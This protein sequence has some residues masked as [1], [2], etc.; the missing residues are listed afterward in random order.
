M[1]APCRGA[2]AARAAG[3]ALMELR[4]PGWLSRRARAGRL[5]RLNPSAFQNSTLA[6][7]AW[8]RAR[9]ASTRWA[10]WGA[11]VGT[12][13]G[14]V[15]FAPASWLAGAVA[16][17]TGQRL[18]LA[19]AKGSIWS[20]DAPAGADRRRRQ[21]RRRGPAGP[22]ALADP[23]ARQRLRTGTE[24]GVLPRPRMGH[25]V[26]GRGFGRYQVVLPPRPQAPGPVAGGM[27]GRPGHAV[28]HPAAW[29]HAAPHQQR[30][31]A[32]VGAGP[33]ARDRQPRRRLCWASRRAC[34]RS[35]RWAA[36]ASACAAAPTP[37]T[38]PR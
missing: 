20:G 27:A 28:Q 1:V 11:V 21:P 3:W 38:R 9:N 6:E 29:R 35:I 19:D 23:A 22:A 2:G 32:R 5:S 16:H 37:A 34:R 18:L 8:Q 14:V 10:L 7:L 30:H 26:Q 15:V 25:P 4:W 13:V 33:L 17:A 31:D 12:L 36:T 24:P